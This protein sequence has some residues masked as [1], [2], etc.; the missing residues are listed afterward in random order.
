MNFTQV[1]ENVTAK[2]STNLR[3]I[4][5]QGADSTGSALVSS[6]CA[7]SGWSKPSQS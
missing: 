1:S 5:S 2:D 7:L 6:Y 3:D 4:P